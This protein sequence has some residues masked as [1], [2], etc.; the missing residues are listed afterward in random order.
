MMYSQEKED[1][2][3]RETLKYASYKN[4]EKGSNVDAWP[5]HPHQH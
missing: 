2:T 3:Q 4:K 1:A 5:Q